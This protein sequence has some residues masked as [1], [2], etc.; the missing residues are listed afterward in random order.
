MEEGWCIV[1][2]D[3]LNLRSRLED[4]VGYDALTKYEYNMVYVVIF[5]IDMHRVELYDKYRD[6]FKGYIALVVLADLRDVQYDELLLREL[7]R[8]CE[9]YEV[10]ARWMSLM[11]DP[12]Q[13]H[14]IPMHTLPTLL[15]IRF[16]VFFC[17]LY[18]HEMQMN[19]K[20]ALMKLI[21]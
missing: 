15:E 8:I 6:S 19:M 14:F 5:N 16:N 13:T 18:N 21:S 9:I 2:N 20:N 4:G 10:M 11:F 1:Y 12:L 3:I 7:V 17:M